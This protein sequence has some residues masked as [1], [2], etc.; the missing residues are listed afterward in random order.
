MNIAVLADIHANLAAFTAVI[1]DIE[2]WQPDAVIIA[3]DIIN[4]GPQPRACLELALQLRA[5]R[6]WH[7]LRGNHEGY[8]LSYDH[9]LTTGRPPQGGK[10][11]WHGPIIWTHQEV[12]DLVPQIKA[13][14]TNMALATRGGAVMVYHASI[15]H[16]RDGLLPTH[17]QLELH[18]KIDSHA[19]VFCTAHTHM[20]F[21]RRVGETL[22]VNVGSVGLPFDGDWRAAYARLT[23][24]QSDWQAQIVR[25]PYD[26]EAT[27][28]AAR[29]V[30]VPACGPIAHIMVREIELARSFLFD[31]VPVYQERVFA[32]MMSLDEAVH[33]FLAEVECAA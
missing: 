23:L 18:A 22:V 12:V 30:M 6:G 33:R 29:A 19:A 4:R 21:V 15:H 1:A 14:P 25:V 5:E 11:A 31:F 2:R 13:L 26:R 24:A 16:D 27:L 17:T 28:R 7:V 32:G 9:D 10:R 3:G 20:P 8:V